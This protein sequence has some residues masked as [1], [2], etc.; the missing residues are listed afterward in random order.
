MRIISLRIRKVYMNDKLIKYLRWLLIVAIAICFVLTNS[1]ATSPLTTYAGDDSAFFRL[2]GQGMKIGKLPYRDYFDQKGP[3]FFLIQYIGQLIYEGRTGAFI[4]QCI[5]MIFSVY[6]MDRCFRLFLQNSWSGLLCEAAG[7][8]SCLFYAATTLGEGNLTEEHALPW[9]MLSAYLILSYLQK[10]NAPNASTHSFRCPLLHG[11]FYGFAVGIM[12]MSRITN[13][14]VLGAIVLTIVLILIVKKEFRNLLLNGVIF[15][16]GFSAS[17]LPILLYCAAHGILEEMISAVYGFGMEYASGNILTKSLRV[18]D[19]RE[20]LLRIWLI[21]SIACLL[22]GRHWNKWL[23]SILLLLITFIGVALGNNYAHYFGMSIPIIVIGLAWTFEAL[24]Q[25]FAEK[26]W[27]SVTQTMLA[28][29]V[30]TF[31]Y[32]QRYRIFWFA[33]AVAVKILKPIPCLLILGIPIL[34]LSLIWVYRRLLPLCQ[35]KDWRFY[36]KPL[37]LLSM[38]LILFSDLQP[39]Y[40]S[41]KRSRIKAMDIQ[42]NNA[43]AAS[44]IASAIP[45]NEKDSV[46][47]YGIADPDSSSAWY[48]HTGIIPPF[49]H[50]DWH[51][52]RVTGYDWIR[53]ETVNWLI[54][55]DRPLWI[56]VPS[57][58]DIEPIEIRSIIADQYSLYTQ[59]DQ[60]LLYRLTQRP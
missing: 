3:F 53:E 51:R 44:S 34:I 30:V 11:F 54:S 27:S 15:V 17:V 56:V 18:L 16:L 19:T 52:S 12:A 6:W 7:I 28:A 58:W 14:A 40:T 50:C 31:L 13:A 35:K 43:Q 49:R 23:L 21:P 24:K 4:V 55:N 9:L 60:Y 32:V 38:L 1:Y 2:V 36:I 25:S 10:G 47:A 22:Y 39:V 45:E 59:N 29:T 33:R 26:R 57:S 46:F 42:Q 5:S 20:Q 41:F 8:V 37:L 48:M